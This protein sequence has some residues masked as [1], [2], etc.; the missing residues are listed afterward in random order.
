M[1]LEFKRGWPVVD[2][3]FLKASY[4]HWTLMGALLWLGVQVC[5]EEDN[6]STNEELRIC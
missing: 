5:C 6:Q 1:I 3:R 2:C 4:P